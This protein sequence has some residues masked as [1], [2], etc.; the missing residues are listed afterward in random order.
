MLD[1]SGTQAF[2]G[3]Y[4]DLRLEHSLGRFPYLDL[5]ADSMSCPVQCDTVNCSA[6]DVGMGVGASTNASTSTSV[7]TEAGVDSYRHLL[8]LRLAH[9][10]ENEEKEHGEGKDKE[11]EKARAT[12]CTDAAESSSTARRASGSADTVVQWKSVQTEDRVQGHLSLSLYGYIRAL[13]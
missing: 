12:A 2:Y 10:K 8:A 1:Q 7:S 5:D 9:E 3:S 4:E 11:R 6:V 13:C